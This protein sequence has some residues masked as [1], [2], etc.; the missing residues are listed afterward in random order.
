[1]RP[2]IDN[3]FRRTDPL[4]VGLRTVPKQRFELNTSRADG[5]AFHL[6]PPQIDHHANVILTVAARV[7]TMKIPTRTAME[8][9]IDR[10]LRSLP[11]SNLPQ[12]IILVESI[13]TETVK[14]S[15]TYLLNERE[16]E[17]RAPSEYV[18]TTQVTRRITMQHPT[19]FGA[20]PGFMTV[21]YEVLHKDDPYHQFSHS[22]DAS[23]VQLLKLFTAMNDAYFDD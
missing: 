20:P 22:L 2:I 21:S 4:I 10:V 12:P 7:F 23:R 9:L 17:G 15:N 5:L 1:M 13:S 11:I 16:R 14:K 3:T 6:L 18:L 8:D 19:T